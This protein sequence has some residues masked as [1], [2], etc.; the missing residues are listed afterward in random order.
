MKQ[1]VGK[2]IGHV[3]KFEYVNDIISPV[4]TCTAGS[5]EK[6]RSFD[7]ERLY[8]GWT[9]AAVGNKVGIYQQTRKTIL[10]V[11]GHKSNSRFFCNW[12]I[13]YIYIYIARDQIKYN[14]LIVLLKYRHKR[15]NYT[16]IN[17]CS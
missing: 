5:V 6:D 16:F 14:G 2:T 11:C 7:S 10:N 12:L 15:H 3:L 13:G 17:R 1:I 8:T 9:D 4:S